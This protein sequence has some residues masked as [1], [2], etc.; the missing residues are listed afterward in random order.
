MFQDT[1]LKSSM[2]EQTGAQ[3][4]RSKVRAGNL[5]TCSLMSGMSLENKSLLF[6]VKTKEMNPCT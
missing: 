2:E 3:T 1:R 6:L 4:I 5:Q